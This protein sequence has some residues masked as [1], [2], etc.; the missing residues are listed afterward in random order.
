MKTRCLLLAT[1]WISFA[2]AAQASPPPPPDFPAL[3]REV[4]ELVRD[5]FLDARRGAQ[6]AEE[7]AGYA[8]AIRDRAAF[9]DATR[10]ILAG[11]ATSHTQYYTPDDPGY[12]DL[13]AIFEPVLHRDP[14]TESLGLAAVER[15]GAWFVYRVFAGGPAEAAGKN[16][17]RPSAP[18]PGSSNGRAAASATRRSG[19]ARAR[20]TR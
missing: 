1:A 16:G 4:L 17:W 10:E 8:A 9:H 19:P 5:R 11:L 13:L 15:D 6:W 12:Y 14:R 18:A 3:G 7:H 20:S 2:A